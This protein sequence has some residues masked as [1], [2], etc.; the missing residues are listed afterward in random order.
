MMI[1]DVRR[2]YFNAPIKTPLYVELPGEDYDEND[3]LCDHVGKIHLSLYGTREAARNWMATLS[4]HLKELGFEQGM[5]SPCAFTHRQRS[6]SLTVHGDDY[7]SAGPR[8]AL[9]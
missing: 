2:A 7:F 1:N 4:S 6:I 8:T 3:R 5:Y 9:L